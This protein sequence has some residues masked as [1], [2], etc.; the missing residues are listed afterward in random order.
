M[1]DK[2]SS[3]RLIP[4][5]YITANRVTTGLSGYYKFLQKI[6]PIYSIIQVIDGP[7]AFSCGK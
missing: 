5:N 1:W 7:P 4:I 3:F 6:E 2:T